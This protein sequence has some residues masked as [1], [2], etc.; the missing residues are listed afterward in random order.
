MQEI[1][2]SAMKK[3]KWILVILVDGAMAL[4]QT[5]PDEAGVPHVHDREIPDPTADVETAPHPQLPGGGTVPHKQRYFTLSLSPRLGVSSGEITPHIEKIGN[6]VVHMAGAWQPAR[7]MPK[8]VGRENN[9]EQLSKD[10]LAKLKLSPPQVDILMTALRNRVDVT[11]GVNPSMPVSAE[12][13]EDPDWPDPVGSFTGIL[14]HGDMLA[15]QWVFDILRDS[16]DEEDPRL[17][18]IPRVP[19]DSITRFTYEQLKAFGMSTESR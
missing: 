19:I 14:P 1:K 17:S 6:P 10:L 11:V 4:A 18:A 13:P 5:V 16:P 3:K 9:L 15:C 7:R 12:T 2:G 8:M